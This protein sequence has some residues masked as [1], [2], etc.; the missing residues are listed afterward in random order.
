MKLNFFEFGTNNENAN[1][2]LSQSN[3][4]NREIFVFFFRR[5]HIWTYCACV[6]QITMINAIDIH[7]FVNVERQESSI[8]VAFSSHCMVCVTDW[9]LCTSLHRIRIYIYYAIRSTHLLP[10]DWI[11][12]Y[13]GGGL[14]HV[15]SG[16]RICLRSDEN[17]FKY[18]SAGIT[19]KN[20]QANERTREREK[21][22]LLFIRIHT[23]YSLQLHA[24]VNMYSN[25]IYRNGNLCKCFLFSDAFRCHSRKASRWINVD[26]L[27]ILPYLVP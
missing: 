17:S 1:A 23:V 3:K 20:L 8:G 13:G 15:P 22:Y 24:I 16:R 9:Y 11:G 21:V 2:I 27:K 19:L 25:E 10:L 18:C 26:G 14:I 7:A 5:W 6:I 12:A 4:L